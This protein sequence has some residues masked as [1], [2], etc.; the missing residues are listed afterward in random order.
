MK[1][2]L[3]MI[4]DIVMSKNIENRNIFQNNLN[5]IFKKINKDSKENI[6][7]PYTLT[8]GDEFQTVYKTADSVF[9]D[10]WKIIETI[11][12]QKVR[13]AIG[14][15]KLTTKINPNQA[16]GMDGPA[17]YLARDGID[18]LKKHDN[19]IIQCF[20]PHDINLNLINKCLKL[21]SAITQKW[22]INSIKILNSI[23][24]D[25]PLEIISKKTGIGIRAIYKNIRS[26]HLYDI[27]D[28]QDEIIKSISR[29][30][31]NP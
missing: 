14:I 31:I 9:K 8:L 5:A 3:A 26:N 24:N 19:T 29:R 7:S 23:M 21:L 18:E 13:F 15:E 1:E 12:P 25:D 6:Y 2:V 27:L 20:S 17:F 11:Y 10:T 22:K 28:L 16:I 4:G 30:L